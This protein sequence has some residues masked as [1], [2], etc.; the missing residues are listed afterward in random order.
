ML[1]VVRADLL[2]DAI[3]ILSTLGAQSE[4]GFAIDQ[5]RLAEPLDLLA[6]RGRGA[7][8]ARWAK[9]TEDHTLWAA[10]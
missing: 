8:G 5:I 3:A 10:G 6:C 7:A 1:H 2:A 9:R 4:E